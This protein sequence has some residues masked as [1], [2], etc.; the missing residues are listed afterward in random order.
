MDVFA[1]MDE[2]DHEEVIFHRD[3]AVGLRVIVA[4]NPP[5]APPKT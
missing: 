5:A 1:G 4:I 3:A 2:R